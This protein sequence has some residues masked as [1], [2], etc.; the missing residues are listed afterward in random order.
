MPYSGKA[1]WELPIFKGLQL[2][3]H[4]WY[5]MEK[6]N[7]KEKQKNPTKTEHFATVEGI[8]IYIVNL[9]QP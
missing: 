9:S 8:S 5:K 2:L 1:L 7:K 4:K 6:Q 3:K